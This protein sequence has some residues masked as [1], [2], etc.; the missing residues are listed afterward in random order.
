LGSSESMRWDNYTRGRVLF[1]DLMGGTRGI[2]FEVM[3]ASI[4]NRLRLGDMYRL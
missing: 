4:S 3:F 1:T 2:H